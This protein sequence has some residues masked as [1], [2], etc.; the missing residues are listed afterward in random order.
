MEGKNSIAKIDTTTEVLIILKGILRVDFYNSKEKYLF[1]KI[2]VHGQIHDATK[3]I[4]QTELIVISNLVKHF[5]T[6]NML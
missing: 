2:S 1:S 3:S 5:K 4:V 6:S